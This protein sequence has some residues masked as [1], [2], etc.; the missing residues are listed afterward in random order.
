MSQNISDAMLHEVAAA[1]ERDPR[2]NVHKGPVGV[3]QENGKVILEGRVEDIAAKRAALATA[4][5]LLGHRHPVLD[6]LRVTP[7]EPRGNLELR[8]AVA[9]ILAGEPVFRDYTLLTQT[10]GETEIVHDAEASPY[11][12]QIRVRNGTVS[13][14]GQV[15]SLSHRRL[16]E[17]LV[18]WTG[19]CENVDNRL[20][21][22]PPEEDNDD[23]ITDAVR[24]VLEKDPLVHAEGM[25]VTTASAV[26][27]LEG[28][29]GNA[30]EKRLAVLDAWSVPGVGDVVDRIEICG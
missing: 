7:T 15:G 26:V 27:T 14:T 13:L 19:S 11:K 24:M 16:A 1:L 4:R 9:R 2:I 25:R 6:L 3:W 28:C 5:R 8:D 22:F 29:A 12:I 10:N 18:W 23:E 21:V 17:V 20:E 30:E